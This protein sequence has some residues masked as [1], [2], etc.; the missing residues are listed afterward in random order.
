MDGMIAKIRD[1]GVVGAGGAG[2]PTAVKLTGKFDCILVNGVECEPLIQVDQHL[3]AL[4]APAL[5]ETLDELVKTSGAGGGIFVIKEK[6]IAAREALNKE[7]GKYPALTVKTLVS[8]YPMGDEQVLV[9]EALGRIV[10]EGG[11]P[12]NVGVVV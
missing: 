9:Y 11:I 8:A 1:A 3:A 10:P 2:F 12:L 6:Y 4:H 7:I 5:L